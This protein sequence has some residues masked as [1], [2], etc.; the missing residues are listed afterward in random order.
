MTRF[1]FNS[2]HHKGVKLTTF[3]YLDS[4]GPK[5]NLLLCMSA[6]KGA[7]LIVENLKKRRITFVSW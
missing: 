3:F 1:Q 4:Y 5:K 2:Y 6:A 7:I